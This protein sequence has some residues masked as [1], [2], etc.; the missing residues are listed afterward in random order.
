VKRETL[1][2][3]PALHCLEHV[4]I[5]TPSIGPDARIRSSLVPGAHLYYGVSLQ[6]LVINGF[7]IIVLLQRTLCS[8]TGRRSPGSLATFTATTTSPH[9]SWYAPLRLPT[10]S[11][12]DAAFGG[13]DH[14]D[15]V[16]FVPSVVEN[17]AIFELAR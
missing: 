11:E 4:S 8:S 7:L 1:D 10:C 6:H 3:C 5:E 15:L 9:H 13:H 17:S 16:P 14:L 12:L 2:I